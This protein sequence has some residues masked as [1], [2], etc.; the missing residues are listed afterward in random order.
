VNNAVNAPAR[1][2][3]D[4]HVPPP[5]PDAPP[6][7]HALFEQ[8]MLAAVR[9]ETHWEYVRQTA[10]EAAREQIE[11][12]RTERQRATS[13][14]QDRTYT[15]GAWL[16]DAPDETPT[17]WG[18]GGDVL[19]ARGESLMIAGPQGVGKTTLASQILKGC[20]SLQAEV[21]GLPILGFDRRV[22]YLAMDRPMQARRNLA[23]LFAGM[24]EHREYLDEMLRVVEGPPPADFA[25]DPEILRQMCDHHGADVAFIDSMKDAAIGLSKD[26]V[27]AGYNR[28]RQIAL[29]AGHQLVELHHTVKSGA[30]GGKPNN[31]N[32]IYGSTWL[33]S[34]AGSVVMLWGEPGDPEV[35]FIH[36]KQPVDVVGPFKVVHDNRTGVSTR[37]YEAEKDLLELARRCKTGGLSA[38]EAAIVMFGLNIAEKVATKDI[39]KARRRLDRYVEQKLLWRRDPDGS[40]AGQ[41]VRWFAVE[42]RLGAPPEAA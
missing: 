41:E 33:T 28:A 15:G 20:L 4:E 5:G 42:R 9:R 31:I 13:A 40:G 26:E 30:D 25:Q 38:K 8:R 12:E 18:Q 1:W 32:G 3:N 11:L 35:E 2:Q 37:V 14:S 36:L 29:A 27:G 17:I 34:G 24:G 10:R 21:L 39:N 6:E 7:E 16:L 23:R 22:L 19:W